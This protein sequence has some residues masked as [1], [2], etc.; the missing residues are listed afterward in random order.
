[1]YSGFDNYFRLLKVPARER[2]R[3]KWK[4]RKLGQGYSLGASDELAELYSAS[5]LLLM[6]TVFANLFERDS[7]V[8][9]AET[10]LFSSTG[11][12]PICRRW[13]VLNGKGRTG[14]K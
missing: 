13:R 11:R 7:R 9:P 1:M 3:Q 6:R 10:V 5:I 14:L 4:S 12:M 2:I 8:V